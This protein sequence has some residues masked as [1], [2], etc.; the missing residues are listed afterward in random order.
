MLTHARIA[1][2]LSPEW[3]A[4]DRLLAAAAILP[5][6]QEDIAAGCYSAPGRLNITAIQHVMTLPAAEL[7]AQYIRNVLAPLVRKLVQP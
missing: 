3:T 5:G 4:E 6:I 7:E 1:Q 2:G